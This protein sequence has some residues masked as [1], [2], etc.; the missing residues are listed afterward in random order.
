MVHQFSHSE[1]QLKAQS[2]RFRYTH[3]RALACQVEELRLERGQCLVLCG[4]SGSGKSSFLHL[5]NGLVPEYY[6][7]EVE[8][9]LQIGGLPY[10]AASVETLAYHVVR[11]QQLNFSIKRFYKSW[12]FLV[13]TKVYH[14]VPFP[15]A[16]QR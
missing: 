1:I 13:R 8:G 14:A 5:I 6:Q 10:Q 16:W 7:G 2:L 11:I 9:S 4:P 12:S 15:S 3:S